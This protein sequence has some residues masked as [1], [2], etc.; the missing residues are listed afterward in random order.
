MFDVFLRYWK[1]VPL[2]PSISSPKPVALK[3]GISAT[4]PSG[5]NLG[6]EL[7]VALRQQCPQPVE[8]YGVGGDNMCASGLKSLFSIDELAIIGLAA[9]FAKIPQG[10]KLA[11]LLVK[12]LENHDIDALVI[13]DSPEF[14]QP[15]ARWLRAGNTQ[16]PIFNLG[17]PTV[18]AWRPWRARKMKPY[19]DVVLGI[20]PFEP[21]VY[22][23]LGGPPCTFVGNP[24]IDR[25]KDNKMTG[26]VFRQKYSIPE[27]RPLLVLLP[28]S[29]KGEI[30]RHMAIFAN[31]VGRFT[32]A[33]G[34]VQV[35]MP[36]IP[37]MKPEIASQLQNIR[38]D[39]LQIEDEAE[40]W[41]AFRA[42]DLALAASGT[43]TLELTATHTPMIVAYQLDKLGF[44]IKWM[45]KVHS[46]VLPN[47]IMRKN[48]IPEFIGKECT[49]EALA[50]ALI[51]L[52]QSTDLRQQQVE[53]LKQAASEAGSEDQNP[54]AIRAAN[55]IIN[56]LNLKAD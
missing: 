23:D 28:G 15:V 14:N 7:M 2:N 37:H 35:V 20:L 29:R 38:L 3:I 17:A 31:A 24:A 9:L 48:L 54:T 45:V 39:V 53:Y 5:D 44:L 10:Y 36:V 13:I 19:I 30:K 47:L 6:A 34:D 12:H 43:V 4:E 1:G 8:F 50:S 55:V 46:V 11:K 16:L 51:E 49:A 22:S 56:R 40:K 32:K 41:G 52:Y 42:A 18:W 26:K 27:D 21:Q 25:A 33:I